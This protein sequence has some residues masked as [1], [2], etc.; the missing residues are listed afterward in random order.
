M[1]S[2]TEPEENVKAALARGLAGLTF[3]EHF[4]THPMDWEGCVYDHGAYTRTIDELRVRYGDRIFI[5]KGIE[6]CYQ[7]DQMGRI[8]PLI[9]EGDF[10]LV[11]LSVHYFG[12]R[13]L[14]VRGE[15]LQAGPE[16]ATRIYLETVREAVQFCGRVHDKEGPV[17]DVL[18]HLDLV[19]RYTQ[20][21]FSTY[22]VEPFGELIDEILRGC[23]AAGMVPEINTSSLRQGLDESMPGLD[24]VKRYAALGGT[25]MS[26]GSDAHQAADVGAG[27]D[28][29]V[30]MLRVAGIKSTAMF[31]R[32]ERLDV[33]LGQEWPA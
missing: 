4:D 7:P 27:F 9:R 12:G 31:R 32:R 11:I 3:T 13:P 25:A 21:F 24:T 20:R 16:E 10:D 1:D 30:E 33:A 28:T 29:A 19:K 2:R 14:H 15:L 6:I 22:G 26:L 8:L 23:L 5:G 18:G 17:F